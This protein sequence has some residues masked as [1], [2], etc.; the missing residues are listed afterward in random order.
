MF[1]SNYF[2]DRENINITAFFKTYYLVLWVIQK[3]A[4]KYFFGVLV[5]R[6]FE[7]LPPLKVHERDKSFRRDQY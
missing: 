7:Y 3:V 2:L 6:P 1:S 4:P 5:V